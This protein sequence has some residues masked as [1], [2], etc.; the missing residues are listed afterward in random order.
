MSLPQEPSQVFDNFDIDLVVK[1]LSHTV[2]S[3]FFTFFIP[4][5][6]LSQGEQI[7]SKSFS[8]S[9]AHFVVVSAFWFIKWISLLY[10]NQGNFFLAPEPLDWSEQIVVITGGSSG[11]GEL[12]ANTLAVRN[13][14]V[15][16]LDVKPIQTENYN[17]TYYKCDVSKWSEVEAVAGRIKGEIGEP[18][19]LVNNAGVVQ[20]KLIL[21]LSEK[22]IEQTFG[23]NTLAHYWT[24]KAFLPSMLKKKLGHIVTIASFMG[25]VGAPRLTDY[26][27]SKAAVI[28]MNSTLRTELD[29]HYK[30]PGIRTTLVCPGYVS[31]S[32]FQT[33]RYPSKKIQRFLF[34]PIEPVDVVKPIIAALDSQLSQT[35]MIPFYTQL[36]PYMNL[37]PSFVFD[38]AQYITFA[39]HAMSFFTKTSGRR[40]DEGPVPDL[41]KD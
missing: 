21:D 19:M 28:S 15:V 30:V 37:M 2:F 33:I 13:V 1:V 41:K 31:T 17:I 22:D 20:G 27:A 34:P 18:T 3:P 8:Y 10:K 26:A 25:I 23:V 4:L 36:G 7:T 32:L 6:Y 40:E 29:N 35:I 38:F 16:V 14:T 39:T 5:F 12:L 9:A 24:I 11:I